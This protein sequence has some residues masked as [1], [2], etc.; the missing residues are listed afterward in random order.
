MKNV[1]LI[2]KHILI[3]VYYL[4]VTIMQIS[5]APLI[6]SFIIFNKLIIIVFIFQTND[7]CE[8]HLAY[9]ITLIFV[10]VF[11]KLFFQQPKNIHKTYAKNFFL[12]ISN[13]IFMQ[14]YTYMKIT[15]LDT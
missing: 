2:I 5:H 6:M 3:N 12:D 15:I 7:R 9:K 14:S 1:N 11:F 13:S 8:G 4:P 10:I